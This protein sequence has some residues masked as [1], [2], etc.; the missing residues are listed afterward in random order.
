[1][2]EVQQAAQTEEYQ[3]AEALI[4]EHEELRKPENLVLYYLE[5]GIL[6]HLNGN[7]RESNQLLSRADHRMEILEVPSISGTAVEWLLSNK[8]Q[9]YKGEDFERVMIHYYM[10]LNYLMLDDLEG[11]LVECRRVNT[12]LREFNDRY[13]QKNVYKTDAFLL[14]LSG[15]IYDALGETNDA[16]IDYRHAYETYTE[17]YREAYST[18]L[19]QQ[20]KANLLRTSQALGFQD[21]FE[22]YRDTFSDPSWPAQQEYRY[23][24]RLV[25]IWENSMIPYK[26]E[27]TFREYIELDEDEDAGCYLKFAFPRL[28]PR[29][30]TFTRAD[31][32]AAGVTQPLELGEDLAQIAEKNLEDRRIRTL[33]RAMSRNVIKCA[34]EYN[35]EQENRFLGFLFGLFTEVTE[36]ADTRQWSLLPAEIHITQLLLPPGR[37]DVDLTFSGSLGQP[38]QRVR[39]EDVPL[40]AG[41]TQF[42]IHRTF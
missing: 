15:I 16:L 36:G 31:V 41:R 40:Q 32:S 39:Y 4:A 19:P 3:Y 14:Y 18:P 10:A 22:A 30:H 1:M 17:D 8:G 7:Y 23:A 11:A 26:V 2:D 28:V 34:V 5:K 6:A 37:T 12:L 20:L 29:F 24:A 27:Q 33:A 21:E 9:P 13:E 25:V 42:I 35:L 38:A